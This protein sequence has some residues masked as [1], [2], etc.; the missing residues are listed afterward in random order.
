MCS[1]EQILT[2]ACLCSCLSILKFFLAETF[3]GGLNKRAQKFIQ[4]A[5]CMHF[6][7]CGDFGTFYFI[8]L[9]TP[10]WFPLFIHICLRHL[11]NHLHSCW[12][13]SLWIY[14]KT[15]WSISNFYFSSLPFVLL[16]LTWRFLCFIFIKSHS[17][18][19][20]LSAVC[21]CG[22]GPGPAGSL[23]CSRPA[24]ADSPENPVCPA[25]PPPSSPET[26][27]CCWGPDS[28]PWCCKHTKS[29]LDSVITPLRFST[30]LETLEGFAMLW[31]YW[32]LMR[33]I[34]GSVF[35]FFYCTLE[36]FIL[37]LAQA[38]NLS[39]L[40]QA[41]LAS[42]YLDQL[43]SPHNWLCLIDKWFK[44]PLRGFCGHN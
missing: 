38:L 11:L 36:S 7:H 2:A 13:K 16:F 20:P 44:H 41:V 33:L 5:A 43:F 37:A 23:A 28:S 26:P 30:M 3:L 18:C 25:K 8:S 42:L 4:A 14:Q 35:F 22:P 32:R 1:T 29:H 40:K 34:S 12:L 39:G 6:P 10:V 15:H 24:G 21:V 31:P 19:V 17:V 27:D 9:R